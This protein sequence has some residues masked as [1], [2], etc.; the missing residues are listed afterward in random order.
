MGVLNRTGIKQWFVGS[1]SIWIPTILLISISLLAIYSSSAYLVHRAQ[2]DETTYFFKRFIFSMM[3]LGAMLFVTR[4]FSFRVL[5]F[6]APVLLFFAIFLMLWTGIA[7]T[8][9]FG[10]RRWIALPMSVSLQSSELAKLTLYIYAAHVLC[11]VRFSEKKRFFR[12]IV[13]TVVLLA[14][15][16]WHDISTAI[17]MGVTVFLMLVYSGIQARYLLFYFGAACMGG[18]LLFF[19]SPKDFGRKETGIGRVTR[20]FSYDIGATS[21][22]VRRQQREDNLQMVRAMIAISRGGFWGVG[23]GKSKVRDELPAS[24]ND[25]IYAIIIEEYG[26]FLGIVILLLFLWLAMPAFHVIRASSRP[27]R[28]LLVCGLISGLLTQ[29]FINMG[30]ATGA[31]FITG[32]PLPL[33]SLGGSS[34]ILTCIT[35]GLITKAT[36]AKKVK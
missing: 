22:T 17:I 11:L 29:A 21:P 24:Y 30:V 3:G 12:L 10:A 14:L 2:M 23:P 20:Y 25:Y 6:F 9:R 36:V 5:R 8:E 15:V 16:A 7:G 28:R 27:F 13:P 31:I 1:P 32:Q 4:F 34:L 19:F 35:L 18:V 26:L 33:V